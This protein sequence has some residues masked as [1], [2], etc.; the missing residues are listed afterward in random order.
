MMKPQ[1]RGHRPQ[2]TVEL[3][4]SRT[5]HAEE[6]DEVMRRGCSRLSSGRRRE[7]IKMCL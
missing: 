5:L 1:A 4:C 7:I 2:A 3:R 6:E